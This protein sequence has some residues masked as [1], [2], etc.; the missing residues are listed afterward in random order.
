M[1]LVLERHKNKLQN[2]FSFYRLSSI[3]DLSLYHYLMFA[4]MCANCVLRGLHNTTLEKLMFLYCSSIE[5]NIDIKKRSRVV[6]Q[7]ALE[8]KSADA[9]SA[10][11]NQSVSCWNVEF[12][13]HVTVYCL[14]M[15]V[16]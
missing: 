3:V 9:S 15:P 8:L 12:L 2:Y 5:L 11:N 4:I 6:E 7:K 14:A 1:Y 13:L 10:P 16:I